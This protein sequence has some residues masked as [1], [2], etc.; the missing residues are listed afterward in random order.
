MQPVRTHTFRFKKL[1]PW[2]ILTILLM[3]LP[4]GIAQAQPSEHSTFADIITIASEPDYPPFCMVDEKGDAAG[5]SV[6]LFRAASQ[7]AGMDVTIQIGEWEHIKEALAKG[8]IDALPLVGRTPERELLFDFTMPYISLHGAIFTRKQNRSIKSMEDLKDREILVMKGDNAEEFVRREGFTS[9]IIT[10]PTFE[11][12]FLRLASGEGDAVIIQQIVG[13]H[14]VKKLNLKNVSALE[15]QFPQF[16]QDFCFAVQKGD[17]ELLSALNEGLSIIIV[18]KTYEEIRNRWFGPYIN[19]EI[20]AEKI[21]RITLSILIPLVILFLVLVIKFRRIEQKKQAERMNREIAEH[22]LMLEKQQKK[23]LEREEQIRML[24][25]STAEGIYGIDLNE[26]CTFINKSAL[27]ILGYPSKES[28]LNK[29]MH[30]LIHHSYAD[31]SEFP[32]SECRIHKVL[33]DGKGTHTDEEVLW[34]SNKTSF[35]SEYYAFPIYNNNQVVGAVVT[36]WDIT[37]RKKSE[38]ELKKIKKDLEVLVAERT[39]ELN[40]KV[41]KLD[42]SQK[43]LL[44]MVEDLNEI[45][46][47][48]KEERRKLELSN[49]ELEAFTYS[50]SHDLRAPLRAINGFSKFLIEDYSDKLDKEGQR[51]IDTIS[52]NA[53]R[54]DQLISDLLNLSRVSR[55][56][57]VPT[58]VKMEDI[59]T[60]MYYE[61]ANQNEQKEFDI[62]IK[63]MPEAKCDSTLV[64]QVW[65][66]LISNALKYSSKS[67]FKKIE[68]GG[69]EKEGKTIYY[70]RDW[71]AGYDPKY[72]HKLF[73]IFQRLHTSDEFEGTGV[74]LAIVKRI[75]HRHGG[76][77]WAEGHL[78]KGATFYFSLPKI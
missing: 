78:D 19:E 31:G 63:K 1:H 76:E 38:E 25:N 35:M 67:E 12:A 14:L 56:S 2:T 44:F 4:T 27:E 46:A 64:K 74:G 72:S 73:G 5:F 53:S 71:G 29:N 23:T 17:N 16:T 69:N 65:Q 52:Q 15:I 45:T 50:V 13:Y 18:D 54:M 30:Q 77:A 62:T 11:E 42:K 24:L 68:I 75:I 21:F 9:N 7:A 60:S 28:V 37:E 48:L 32:S 39:S 51:F 22:K 8:E 55:V 61:M 34:R 66:N 33:K 10:T 36:F 49:K 6:D 43:A 47:E 26:N 58:N 40:E 70:I 59:A 20:S 57:L 41:L 3:T